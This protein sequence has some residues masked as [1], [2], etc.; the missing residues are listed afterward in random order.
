MDCRKLRSANN[1]GGG[2]R[3]LPGPLVAKTE[4]QRMMSS[5]QERIVV[6][7][8]RIPA[9]KVCWRAPQTAF[10]KCA[11]IGAKT[12][13]RIFPRDRCKRMIRRPRSKCLHWFVVVQD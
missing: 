9:V 3:I 8:I 4:F 7:L 1:T 6:H 10:H 12:S 11:D 2:P 13:R 5:G